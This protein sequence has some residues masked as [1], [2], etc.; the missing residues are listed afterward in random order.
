MAHDVKPITDIPAMKIE[1]GG[2]RIDLSMKE[3]IHHGEDR[4]VSV[5]RSE[6][7]MARWTR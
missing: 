3:E 6:C 4:R 1:V 5:S 2:R 7:S